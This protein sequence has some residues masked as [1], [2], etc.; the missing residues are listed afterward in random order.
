M[1]YFFK[2][3]FLG[4]IFLGCTKR[5]CVTTSDLSF[6][7]LDEINRTFY[8]FS[9]DSFTVSICQ[10][11]TPNND[12]LNDSF[13]IQS[14]L[15]SNDYSSTKFRVVNAC[16]EVVHLEKNTFPF[17]FPNIESLEDGQYSFNLSVMIDRD[18][19][20]ISGSGKIRILRK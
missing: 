8:D 19:E 20:V 13:V 1:K 10:Y 14:N 16:E 5:N 12:G 17:T 7:Q 18:K 3:I 9:V 2:I 6:D 11:I 15:D 4:V